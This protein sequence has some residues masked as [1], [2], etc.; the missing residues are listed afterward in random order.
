M[1]F[2]YRC[3]QFSDYYYY[4]ANKHLF[5]NIMIMTNNFFYLP[6]R[7]T[8]GPSATKNEH[9]QPTSWSFAKKKLSRKNIEFTSVNQKFSGRKVSGLVLD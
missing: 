4:C 6:Y 7:F 3:L 1:Y 8:L 2:Y 5:D 9:G